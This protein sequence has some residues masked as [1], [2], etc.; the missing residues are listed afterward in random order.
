MHFKTKVYPDS[1]L[2]HRYLC[3]CTDLL[4]R[5]PKHAAVSEHLIKNVLKVFIK[6]IW[7]MVHSGHILDF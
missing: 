2:S 5:A 3:K 6:H 4:P 1:A 7:K